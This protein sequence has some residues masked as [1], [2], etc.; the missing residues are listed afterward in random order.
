M[1]S[2][3]REWGGERG[4]EIVKELEVGQRERERESVCDGRGERGG[5]WIWK[6]KERE[7]RTKTWRDIVGEWE[8]VTR[9]RWKESKGERRGGKREMKC[10]D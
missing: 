10:G 7:E 1:G 9:E 8:G 3:L 4:W 2:N 5:G 6:G